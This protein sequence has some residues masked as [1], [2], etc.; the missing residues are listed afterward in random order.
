[1]N[2]TLALS[3]PHRVPQFLP[4]T[5]GFQFS[6]SAWKDMNVKLPVIELP[7]PLDGAKIT[8]TSQGMGGG[9][10]FA[11]RDYYESGLVPPPNTQP[12]TNQNDPLFQYLRDRLFASWD[13]TR[14]GHD[15]LANP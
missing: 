1:V 13:V 5:S 11:A 9:M 8:D 10:I 12:P 15:Y 6:N 3:I 7:A 2:F 4:S 14:T